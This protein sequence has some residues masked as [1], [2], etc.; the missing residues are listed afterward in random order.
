MYLGF[1]SVRYG[2]AADM[3]MIVLDKE[4]VVHRS[5]EAGGRLCYAGSHVEG[6]GMVRK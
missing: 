2:V 6:S 1:V 4:V 5:T 3:K